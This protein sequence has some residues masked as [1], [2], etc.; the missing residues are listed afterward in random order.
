M[1]FPRHR[2]SRCHWTPRRA[3]G[4]CS[5]L[6]WGRC[7]V[8]LLLV[9]ALVVDRVLRPAHARSRLRLQLQDQDALGL[10]LLLLL[11]FRSGVLGH[12]DRLRSIA[13]INII[14]RHATCG[15]EYMQE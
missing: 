4:R 1:R 11:L 13:H 12:L 7:T 6:D 9:H 8:G 2:W 5:R 15:K 10:L 3:G 14:N